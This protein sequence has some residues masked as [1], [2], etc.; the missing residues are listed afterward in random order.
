MNHKFWQIV[1]ITLLTLLALSVVVVVAKEPEPQD[2][3]GLPAVNDDPGGRSVA[4]RAVYTYT[5]VITVTSAGDP[6]DSEG[7]VCYRDDI[8]TKTPASPCTLRRALVEA[9]ALSDYEP[10]AEPI[11]IKFNIPTT[12]SYNATLQVWTIE[13]YDTTD[14][15]ALPRMEGDQ[16]IVDGDTQ[17][18]IGGR[19][20]GPKII[21]RGPSGNQNGM[22]IDGDNNIVRGLAFQTLKNYLY[23][24]GDNNLVEDNWFGLA[25]DGQGLHLRNDLFPEDGSGYT[26]IDF[27]GGLTG[28]IGNTVCDNVFAGFTGV[29]AAIKGRENIFTGN[30]VGTIADGTVPL[31]GPFDQHPCQDG[32]WHGGSGISIADRDHQIGGP[33]EADRNV[34]AGLYLELFEISTQPPAMRIGSGQD[35][36]IQNNYIGLDA[37]GDTIGVCGRGMDMLS[38]AE[39]MQ[40]ISNTIVEPGLSA[41]MANHWTFNGNTLRGNIIK[42]ESAWP[43]KLPGCDSPEDAI[44]FADKVPAALRNFEP[45]VVTEVSGTLVSGVSGSSL[46][47]QTCDNC[48][49]ELFLEDTDAVTGALQ[50]LAVVTADAN[51]DWTATLGW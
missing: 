8:P 39:A 37:H 7:K 51:G 10:S 19:T 29:A 40:V 15:Y 27:A 34:F 9:S 35:H 1:L 11:L 20:D 24:N 45:A 3:I 18:E 38:G 44:A 5:T 14:L 49:I 42:R 30:L 50:S 41:I 6:D 16:I 22:P 31:Q 2:E 17:G 26:G 32:V 4:A 36:L 13:L 21:I 46:T 28:A 47:G 25:D 12:D 48:T 23:L 43:G 33:D